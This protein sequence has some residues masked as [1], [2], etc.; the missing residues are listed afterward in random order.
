MARSEARRGNNGGTTVRLLARARAGD[1]DALD[2]LF[3]R[4]G[5]ELRR[6]AHGR[7]PRQAR[8]GLDT[9]D[10]VQDTLLQTFLHLDRF[11][12]RGDGA[13]RAYMRQVLV[14][15][16]RDEYR[17]AAR[18]QL[19]EPLPADAA[20]PGPSPLESAIGAE[21]LARYD[22][23][24]MALSAAERELIIARI[25]LGLSFPEIAV[26]TGRPSANAA[27]MAVVRALMRLS[28]ALTDAANPTPE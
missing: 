1:R 12:D 26:A 10:L 19:P 15:R 16:I 17:R 13:L 7:L 27:R 14:N 24:L 23:A 20:A 2:Q 3:E 18:R 8:Q 28:E 21:A 11:E 5:P 4:Y 25:E 22:A 6:L 9:P